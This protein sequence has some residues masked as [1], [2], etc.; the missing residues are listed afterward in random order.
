MS[1]EQRSTLASAAFPHSWTARVL[2][3]PPLIAPARH[4]VYPQFVPGEEDALSR[5]AM[6]LEVR[7]AAG[8][9]FLATCALGFRGSSLPAGAW[10]CPHPDNLLALAGG[11][12]YLVNTLQPETCEHLSLRPVTQVIP[13]EAEG[14]L[15][16]AGFH[17]VLA[18]GAGGVLW[19]SARLTW[20]GLTLGQVVDGQMHGT[21]WNLPTDREV[22]FVLNLRTGTHEGGGYP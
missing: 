15:L 18:I 19:T 13:V 7:P 16:L 1:S 21:G 22:P 4:F 10:A 5:G 8:G 20:E 6:L 2:T 17:E 14:L 9:L 11:Y 3:A 12:A